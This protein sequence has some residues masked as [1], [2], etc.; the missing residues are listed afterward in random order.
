MTSPDCSDLQ[1][2]WYDAVAGTFGLSPATFRMARVLSPLGDTSRD[3]WDDFD[4]L[5]AESDGRYYEPELFNRFSDDYGAMVNLILPRTGD[6]TVPVAQDRFVKAAG[7]YAYSRTIGEARE[8]VVQGSAL[9]VSFSSGSPGRRLPAAVSESARRAAVRLPAGLRGR[10]AGAMTRLA[11]G[12]VQGMA[13]FQHQAQVRA[14]PLEAIGIL[15]GRHYPAWFCAAALKYAC[16]TRDNT[17]WPEGLKPDWEQMFGPSGSLRHRVGSLVLVD[18]VELSLAS[19]ADLSDDD[20]DALQQAAEACVTPL[21]ALPAPA[22]GA[23][24]AWRCS[25]AA[26]EDRLEIHLSSPPGNVLLFG[27]VFLETGTAGGAPGLRD[28]AAG[29]AEPTPPCRFTYS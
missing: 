6:D 23:N 11:A 15:D 9:T 14:S 17:V 13:T 7:V 2:A 18:G 19:D 16:R 29:I 26:A 8:Q 4:S 21:F 1:Q 27:V 28:Q 20:R 10:A 5:P 25:L 3:L 22:A 24:A 12:Q